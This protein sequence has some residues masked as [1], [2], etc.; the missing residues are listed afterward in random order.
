[1]SVENDKVVATVRMLPLKPALSAGGA[2]LCVDRVTV[3]LREDSG[4][5][6]IQTMA[7]VSVR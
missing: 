4:L 7:N 2:N 3:T 1:M 6:V 5:L